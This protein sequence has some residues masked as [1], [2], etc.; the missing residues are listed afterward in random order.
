MILNTDSATDIHSIAVLL[1]L[2]GLA[3]IRQS[4]EQATQGQGT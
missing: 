4:L 2:P 1:P 3:Y